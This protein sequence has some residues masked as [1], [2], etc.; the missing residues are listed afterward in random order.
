MKALVE[1][2]LGFHAL[3]VADLIAIFEDDRATAGDAR[4]EVLA[5]L[6][7]HPQRRDGL[8]VGVTGTPGSG[9][10]T[11]LGKLVL[12]VSGEARLPIAVVAVDPSSLS[13]GGA[14][15]GDR[16]RVHLPIDRPELFFRSQASQ[17]ELGGLG[18]RTYPVC[19]LLRLL[20]DVVFVETVG[21]GQSELDVRWLADRMY[22]VMQPL[23][24]DEVQ[25]LKAGVL[26]V[27]DAVVV[28]KCDEGVPARRLIAALA[29]ALPLTR[30]L[31]APPAVIRTSALT[32]EGVA[33]LAADILAHRAAPRTSDAEKDARYFAQWVRAEWGRAGERMLVA[34][35]GAV[36]LLKF[37]PDLDR[38]EARFD[39]LMR[40]A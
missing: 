40:N 12:A 17:S 35:R 24:G 11:L 1:R 25:L 23:G 2:A 8:V 38:A 13:S 3:S 10:S 15:L 6:A 30:V 22:L 34:S 27:P 21:I 7:S 19:Q 29:V 5:I 28:S 4:R 32:G 14:L 20:F 37:E 16:V 39:A 9:K 33:E 18:P 36:E 31:A 26:E